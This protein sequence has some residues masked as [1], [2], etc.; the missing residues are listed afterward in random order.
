MEGF[1]GLLPIVLIV[2][3][4]YF[5]IIRPQQKQQK[6]RQQML[7]SLQKNDKVITIGGIHGVITDI[8]DDD[9]IKLKI[10]DNLSVTISKF[11]VQQI[12]NNE[13]GSSSL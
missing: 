13:G 10:A 1:M 2:V 9:T 5:L 7:D 3:V 12:V 4:F 11:G 8:K 6:Q